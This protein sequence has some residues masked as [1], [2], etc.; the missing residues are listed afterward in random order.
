[1]E[2]SEAVLMVPSP[3]LGD[4]QD[5]GTVKVLTAALDSGKPSPPLCFS[6][7]RGKKG[8]EEACGVE[9][10]W[11]KDKA[12]GRKEDHAGKVGKAPCFSFCVSV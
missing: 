12:E 5:D 1:M 7:R 6:W 8:R 9:M 11:S 2:E 3:W 4:D 10:L